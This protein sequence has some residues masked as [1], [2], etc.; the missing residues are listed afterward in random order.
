MYQTPLPNCPQCGCADVERLGNTRSKRFMCV[1]GHRFEVPRRRGMLARFRGK[2]AV[3][4]ESAKCSNCSE[5][6]APKDRECKHCGK[7]GPYLW[8]YS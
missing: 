5:P 2:P 4:P 6:V 8:E 1:E 3:K 7:V